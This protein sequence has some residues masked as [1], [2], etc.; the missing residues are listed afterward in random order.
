MKMTRLVRISKQRTNR[1]IR[2]FFFA[3]PF[4]SRLSVPL[5]QP[6]HRLFFP[7]TKSEDAS[8]CPSFVL[9]HSIDRRSFSIA[10]T[11]LLLLPFIST[12][13]SSSTAASAA[14]PL[15]SQPPSTNQDLSPPQLDPQATVS[16]ERI[17]DGLEEWWEQNAS[18]MGFSSTSDSE[19]SDVE[20]D[21]DSASGLDT[22]SESESPVEDD[23]SELAA[24]R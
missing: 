6:A 8:S 7:T 13:L 24:R 19:T 14:E 17:E 12:I 20:E 22:S 21:G 16:V 3:I 11:T 23:D 15:S 2:L 5:Q 10:T 4:L 9:P 1:L 18:R